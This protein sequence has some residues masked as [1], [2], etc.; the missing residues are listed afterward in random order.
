MS[1]LSDVVKAN[2]NLTDTFASLKSTTDSTFSST[3]SNTIKNVESL[4]KENSVIGI[5]VSDIPT[6][7]EAINNYVYGIK[8]ALNELYNYDP[9]VAFKGEYATAM[10][11]Y[12]EAIKKCCSAIA[13]NMLSFNDQLT[14][15]QTAYETKATQSAS[16]IKQMGASASSAYTEYGST[17]S[18]S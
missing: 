10:A 13:S 15:V 16:V 18:N 11:D 1:S 12:I 17:G 5:R 14:N 4:F 7:K 2:N 8:E 3:S 6:M 9:Q